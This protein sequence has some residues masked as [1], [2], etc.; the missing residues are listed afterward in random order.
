MTQRLQG[1][2]AVVTGAASGIGAATARR[3]TEEG[4]LLVLG[5]LDE[6][7]GKDIAREFGATFVA[8]DVTDET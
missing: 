5:D 3:F 4:A 2:V 1:R 8:T 7:G 6:V